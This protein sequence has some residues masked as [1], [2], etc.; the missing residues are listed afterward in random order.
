MKNIINIK[1]LA[2]LVFGIAL[3]SGSVASESG[4]EK[5]LEKNSERSAEIFGTRIPGLINDHVV[6]GTAYSTAR[7]QFL[8]H[9][10]ILGRLSTDYGSPKFEFILNTKTTYEDVLSQLNGSIDGDAIIEAISIGAGAHIAKKSAATEYAS[11]YTFSASTTPKKAVL[12]PLDENDGFTLSP[13]GDVLAAEF[14]LDLEEMAGD[15]F[16]SSIEYGAQL[17]VNMKIEYLNRQDKQDIGGYLDVSVGGV[18]GVKGELNFI[19]DEVKNSVKI[20]VRAMQKGGDPKRLLEIIPDNI[21]SCTLDNP[22]PCFDLFA[23]AIDYAKNKFVN[24][25]DSLSDYN[26][27]NY[28]TSRYDKS[29]LD[30]RRL[31]PEY[32]DISFARDWR[33][34][35]AT[36]DYRDAILDEQRASDLIAKYYSWMEGP[37]RVA[38]ENIKEQAYNNAWLYYETIQYCRSH[39]YGD[40]CVEYWDRIDLCEVEGGC[41]TEYDRSYLE[42]TREASRVL[43]CENAR[44]RSAEQGVVSEVISRLYQNLRWAPVF[45]DNDNPSEG[46]LEWVACEFA[47]TTYGN[48]FTD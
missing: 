22:G 31:V 39:P 46:V 24:Q 23:E 13:V 26:V 43:Q 27:V 2:N 16:V 9:Q 10:P 7:R 42:I 34:I 8:N 4:I 35:E 25:F 6:L 40:L 11:S 3:A 19:S 29:P 47:L 38:V 33:I 32:Q 18:V 21:I 30:I 28:E 48:S 15:E 17:F 41:I 1:N 5:F 14:Q 45:V 37:Q 12:L 20:T 44:A 36:D